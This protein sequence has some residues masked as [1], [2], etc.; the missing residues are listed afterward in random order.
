MN[1]NTVFSVA[2]AILLNIA[3]SLG[4]LDVCGQAT[5]QNTKIIGGQNATAGSWPWQASIQRVSFGGYLCSGTLINK[6]W[7]LSAA[8]CFRNNPISDLVV[9]LGR[10]TQ[11]GLNPHETNRTV[12]KVITHPEY[13]NLDHK[14]ALLQ[15]SSPVTFSDYI[16]PVC[17]AAAGSIFVDGTESWVTGWG[18]I[19]EENF[20]FSD[21]LQ[22]LKSAVVNNFKCNVAHRGIITDNLICAGFL[23]E[24]GKGPCM[25]DGGS[26]LVSKQGSKWIQSGITVY[27]IGCG[28][29]EYPTVYIRVSEYQDWISNY[30]NSSMP[31]FVP[32]PLILSVGDGDSINLLPF[33]VALA[34]S[35]IPL[36]FLHF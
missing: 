16:K 1:F 9:Y 34:F 36:I 18:V 32:F 12:I 7:V 23:N 20:K 4:Q 30:T 5:P 19:N 17:L 27:S 3:A 14:L 13:D 31:G 29:P 15:L 35:I 24:S 2:G 6:E 10:L 21:I 33:S 8:D 28:Q 11:N 22:E 26:P 25:G